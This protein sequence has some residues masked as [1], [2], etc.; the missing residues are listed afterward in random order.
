[1]IHVNAFVLK[2]DAN[3]IQ[4]QLYLIIKTD[5]YDLKPWPLQHLRYTRSCTVIS[6]NI[7]KIP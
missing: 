5:I 1:M 2:S 3:V 7:H 4:L 6:V